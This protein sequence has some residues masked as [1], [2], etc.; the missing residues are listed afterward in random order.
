MLVF[1]PLLDCG[2]INYDDPDYVTANEN[3]RQGLTFAGVKW[4]FH[5]SFA[6]NWHPFTWLSHMLDWQI[7]GG[8]ASGHH[9]TSLLFHAANTVLL[10]FLL[11]RMTQAKWRSAF[12]AALFAWHPLHVESV[13]WVSER[14]DVL[15]TFFFCLTLLS[16]TSYVREKASRG[17]AAG[18]YCC[19]LMFFA[20][21][22]LS[23][24]M[25][26]TLPF[27]LLLLDY[28]PLHRF[29]APGS[30]Q[31]KGTPAGLRMKIIPG[32]LAEKIPFLLLSAASCF[33][34]YIVQKEWGAVS[35]TLSLGARCANAIVSYVRYIGK[36]FWPDNL[37]ILYPLPDQWPGEVVLVS[38]LVIAG[39]SA[40]S[41]WGMFRWPV[42]FTGWFW[43]VGTLVPV[44]G[45]V[46]VGMQAMANRYS[47]V[48]YIGL[49]IT[50]TW[51]T[52]DVLTRARL[53][54][55]PAGL[56]ALVLAACI[57]ITRLELPHWK[58]S[59]TLFS[60]ALSVTKDNPVVHDNL[61]CALMD[62]GRKQEA[63]PH[64][65]EAVRLAPRFANPANN[66][67]AFLA[68]E[69]K[70]DEAIHYLNIARELNPKFAKAH[71][72]LG[73]VMAAVGRFEEAKTYYQEAIRLMPDN[74]EVLNNLAWMFAASPSETIR[75]GPEA[76]RLSERACELTAYK[77]AL[78]IGTLAAAYAEAGRFEDAVK[79]AERA[80]TVAL[81]AKEN[82]IAARNQALAKLYA[83]KKTAR[84][85][86]P[87]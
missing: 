74:A 11:L 29:T 15:S 67:G 36:M 71:A 31:G 3:V 72:K 43:F 35:L 68:E 65:Y 42:I 63:W 81:A 84:D 33:V 69:G 87:N 77:K 12:V 83:E 23:K 52:G 14:K 49:F 21:G 86:T 40:F 80:Q 27:L 10:F 16:Y 78:F 20:A 73:W 60:Q 51:L 58:D 5:A 61:G 41:M 66:L 37:S 70:V 4:A 7:H 22:L 25:L 13:A 53:R 26:V 17:K 64:F 50:I 28:W 2:F 45:I 1:W 24:P 18:R 54:W 34:T 6:S 55:L 38:A 9:L 30:N 44:I 47:Y 57:V 56:A 75:N 8:K 79:M 39:V 62:A 59:I 32:L 76:I 82:D 46:Q 19:T 85:A 48:P